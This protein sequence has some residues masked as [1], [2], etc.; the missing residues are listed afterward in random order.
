[1]REDEREDER[2]GRM[3]KTVNAVS[4]GRVYWQ[5]RKSDGVAAPLY[6]TGVKACRALA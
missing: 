6:R 5:F 2:G 3:E 4:D 1:M